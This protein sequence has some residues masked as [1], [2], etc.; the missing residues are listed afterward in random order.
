MVNGWKVTAII[1]IV[2]FILETA[3]IFW[4]VG[5]ANESTALENECYYD[6][7]DLG[8]PNSRYDTWY[9][10]TVDKVC[11]CYVDGEVKLTKYLG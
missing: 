9:V 7:C 11:S 4:A 10:D 2:L 8:N 3:F 1:F 5:L 6:I